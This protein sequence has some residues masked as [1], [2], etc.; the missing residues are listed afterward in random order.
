MKRAMIAV[1]LLGASPAFADPCKAIPDRGPMPGWVKPLMRPGAT[2]SGRVVHII[3]GDGLC[4]ATVA[5]PTRPETW[6]EIRIADFAAP[7]IREPGGK[8]AKA[9]MSRL[10]LGKLAVCTVQRDRKGRSTRSFDRV[11]ASCSV[12]GA[13]L[14]DQL[15]RAGVMEGGR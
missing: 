3:D 12:N 13:G 11:I 1:V 15:R 5:F 14:A 4:L 2:F 7:E 8:E 10:A 6:L 9:V